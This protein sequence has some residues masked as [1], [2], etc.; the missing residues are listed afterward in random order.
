MVGDICVGR[1]YVPVCLHVRVRMCVCLCQEVGVRVGR[2]GCIAYL[3]FL[4][5]GRQAGRQRR[6]EGR[7]DRL[8]RLLILA[9]SC[10]GREGIV[11]PGPPLLLPLLLSLLLLSSF[12]PPPSPLL[13]LH[14]LPLLSSY[15]ASSTSFPDAFVYGHLTYGAPTDA[16][17]GNGKDGPGQHALL[18]RPAVT[19]L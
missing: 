12:S 13:P 8:P 18:Y 19:A 17:Q 5:P 1:G 9:D 7:T 16:A 4:A 10:A 11:L 6:R 2:V 14:H 3:F 15:L